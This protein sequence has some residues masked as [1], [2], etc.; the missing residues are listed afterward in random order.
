MGYRH[1]QVDWNSV[2]AFYDSGHTRDECMAR[3][4]FSQRSWQAAV[5]KGMV[6]PRAPGTQVGPGSTRFKVKRGLEQGKS[7]KQLAKELGVSKSTVAFH[8]RRLGRPV[9]DRFNR[10][11]DWEA[12]QRAHDAGLRALECC[13][14]FGFSRATW[15]KAVET[16]RIKPRSHLIPLEDLLVK[17]RRTS[18]GHLKQ[19]L[20]AAGLKKN[21]CERCGL[22][23]WQGLPINM[24]LHHRNGDGQDNR[25]ENLE[26]LC[27]NCHSQTENWGGRNSRR[28]AA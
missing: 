12:V 7:Y 23:E 2:Q 22:T 21:R 27:A 4:G 1:Q 8:A 20:V 18:R 11:Y 14:R 16:G 13:A 28:R 25:L 3:F 9:D 19:R 24:Q 15:C 5:L 10:R 6:V 26:F 17:G